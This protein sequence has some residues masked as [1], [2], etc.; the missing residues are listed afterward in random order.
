MI[1]PKLVAFGMK[2]TMSSGSALSAGESLMSEEPL[3][4][5]Q[6]MWED[7]VEEREDPFSLRAVE[8]RKLA[9]AVSCLLWG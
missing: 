9:E 3:E 5:E 6:G 4:E 2:R 7:G 1:S 8:S